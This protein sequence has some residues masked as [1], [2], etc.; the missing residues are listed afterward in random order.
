M[1]LFDQ[2]RSIT[3]QMSTMLDDAKA[4]REI[5][6]YE[7]ELRTNPN[8]VH[9]LQE[10]SALYQ[11]IGENNKAAEILARAADLHRQR[12]SIDL[13]LGLL[14]QAERL[15]TKEQRPAIIRPLVEIYTQLKRYDEAAQH[16]RQALD[17]FITSQ[18]QAEAVA[19]IESL[20][21]LGK[22]DQL[23]RGEFMELMRVGPEG[24]SVESSGSWVIDKATLPGGGMFPKISDKFPEQTLLIADDDPEML[25]VLT[26]L[27]V[28]FDCK[29]ITATN[30]EEALAKAI[31]HKPTL[32][33][34]DLIMPRMDGCE[35]FTALRQHPTLSEVPFV[36]MSS[37]GQEEER[38]AALAQGVEEYWVKPFVLP[39]LLFKTRNLLKRL[40][41][42]A[43]LSGRLSE[44][45]VVE[46]LQFLDSKKNTGILTLRS[47]PHKAW[48]YISDGRVINATMDSI[49]GRMVI[50]KTVYWL[51]G[52]FEFRSCQ[53]NPTDTIEL[54]TQTLVVEAIRRYQQAQQI[55]DT[56]PDQSLVFKSTIELQQ[57]TATEP[58]LAAHFNYLIAVFNGQRSL[59][60]C[61]SILN[62]DLETLVLAQSL[63]KQNYLIPL[64]AG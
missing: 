17:Y 26:T 33:V 39:E 62:G 38:L 52:D 53:V 58:E 12:Q 27:F 60:E 59:Q 37:R 63:I 48:V 15:A 40:R 8:S 35:F 2:I 51:T 22:K 25:Q 64:S 61:L 4:R 5:D 20:P 32:I 7:Q 41:P 16:I 13:A 44:M 43:D 34:S 18:K 30:G 36:C 21:P 6:H 29:I 28:P 42:P 1:G 24:K 10:L 57:L 50:Y 55:I 9:A 14:R 46:L 11:E 47:K 23:Y 54:P 31:E 49:Q 19:F 3:H 56:L 45:S